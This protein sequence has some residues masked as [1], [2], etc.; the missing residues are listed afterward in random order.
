MLLL[1]PCKYQRREKY[2]ASNKKIFRSIARIVPRSKRRREKFRS[3]A[4]AL[5]AIAHDR[6][7]PAIFF[8]KLVRSSD[9][10]IP[11]SIRAVRAENFCALVMISK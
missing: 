2:F 7:I 5:E 9:I 3:R 10:E 4:T 6:E 8:A 1:Y 11:F